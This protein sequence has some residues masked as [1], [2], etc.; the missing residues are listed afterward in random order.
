MIRLAQDPA[1]PFD[2]DTVTVPHYAG[3]DVPFAPVILLAWIV[4]LA[5][6]VV[7]TVLAYFADTPE[8]ARP[9]RAAGAVPFTAWLAGAFFLGP[10]V[11]SQ[12]VGGTDDAFPNVIGYVTATE[13]NP[14]GEF[15]T[16]SRE[17]YGVE[18]TEKQTEA[19]RHRKRN[20]GTGSE[21]VSNVV[22]VGDREVHG[23]FEGSSIRLMSGGTELDVKK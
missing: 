18:L 15:S 12:L 1:S 7:L 16:W 23:Y 3:M 13:K 5:A 21:N 4:P 22:L 9:G 11:L 17:R 6:L 19:L 8:T 2:L 10:V 20:Y 14:D